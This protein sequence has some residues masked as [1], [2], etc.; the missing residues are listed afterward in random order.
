MVSRHACDD[1][2]RRQ[3]SSVAASTGP[4][5]NAR[6]RAR[7]WLG[8]S[9]GPAPRRSSAPGSRCRT[10]SLTC[11]VHR[12][13]LT[14]TTPH[15]T[16]PNPL[17]A[18]RTRP[19]P[20]RATSGRPALP[21]RPP[22]LPTIAIERARVRWTTPLA[23]TSMAIAREAAC[24]GVLRVPVPHPVGATQQWPISR[25]PTRPWRTAEA[26]SKCRSPTPC[27]ADN[28]RV[29][30][31]SDGNSGRQF[32]PSRHGWVITAGT[33]WSCVRWPVGEAG[34][35]SATA[36]YPSIWRRDRD[37]GRSWRLLLQAERRDALGGRGTSLESHGSNNNG[38]RMTIGP[39][40]FDRHRAYG[41]C[42]YR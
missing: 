13:R 28:A 33:W 4:T 36:P 35:S 23:S 14:A 12:H 39:T 34:L 8:R 16:G 37:V 17:A 10:T 2:S 9:A 5:R 3:C 21:A 15:S 27:V 24:R 25:P 26:S 29:V 41:C 30:T 42:G 6:R 18:I 7:S 22:G 31:R 1:G 20:F 38:R 11:A 19:D 40:S 32:G